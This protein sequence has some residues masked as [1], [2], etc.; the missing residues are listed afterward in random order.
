MVPCF[1]QRKNETL[2]AIYYTAIKLVCQTISNGHTHTHT[3]MHTHTQTQ[4][5]TQSQ[6]QTQTQTKAQTQTQT[7]TQAQTQTRTNT[8]TNTPSFLPSVL[9]PLYS[10]TTP[11]RWGAK[12]NR[13]IVDW[14][15]D[16]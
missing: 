8:H 5:Q 13:A 7:Q 16:L 11:Q 14:I 12:F 2:Q 9:L 3:H 10:H 15:C 1:L 6:T 4:A